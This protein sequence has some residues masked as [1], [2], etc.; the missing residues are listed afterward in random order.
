MVFFV[1]AVISALVFSKME[2]SSR[3]NLELSD[4]QKY[5]IGTYKALAMI[6]KKFN[7]STASSN[8]SV[9]DC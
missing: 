8:L 2:S 7:R 5:C 1:L 4:E 6:I 9:L 3:N